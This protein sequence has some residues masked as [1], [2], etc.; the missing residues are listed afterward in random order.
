MAFGR[1]KYCQN[2]AACHILSPMKIEK[3][4]WWEELPENELL[5]V[6]LCDLELDFKKAPHISLALAQ[7]KKEIEKKGLSFKPHFWISDEW[8]SPDTMPGIAIPFYLFH[9]K[10][11]KLE[12]NFIGKVEGL[13]P[14]HF[15][16]LLRHETGHAFESAYRIRKNKLR[17]ELFGESSTPYPNEYEA[18]PF[19]KNYVRHLEENYAQ[20]HPDE[21][22]AETFAVW[23]T[24]GS[25]WKNIYFGTGAYEKLMGMQNLMKDIQGKRALVRNR[26]RMDAIEND[27]RTIREY[28]MSKKKRI[29][30]KSLLSSKYRLNKLFTPV[31]SHPRSIEAHQALIK[32]K[33]MIIGSIAKN[34]N[35]YQ[36]NVERMF[37]NLVRECRANKLHLKMKSKDFEVRLKKELTKNAL[38]YF[39][40]GHHRILM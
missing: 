29:L 7:L 9:P 39:E 10:L 2:A 25:D 27:K 8:F 17:S 6:R 16:K 15:M 18:R 40:E 35:Q 36:Y 26:K 3:T 11:I 32:H 31:R 24:P 4:Y 38:L 33:K 14:D 34:T 19:S 21:D 13:R 22:F 20:A 12:K 1:N 5:Q 37:K 23:L 28:L 30:K